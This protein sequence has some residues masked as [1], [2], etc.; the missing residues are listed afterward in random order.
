MPLVNVSGALSEAAQKRLDWIATAYP[1]LPRSATVAHIVN[2]S[3]DGSSLAQDVIVFAMPSGAALAIDSDLLERFPHV[4]RSEVAT[5]LGTPEKTHFFY[6]DA[7]AA[8]PPVNLAYFGAKIAYEWAFGG[9]PT[10]EVGPAT[11]QEGL[12][13]GTERPGP[14]GLTYVLRKF[15]G[16]AFETPMWVGK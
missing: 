5:A 3:P 15:Q 14:A 1:A 6:S 9:K 4:T 11:V 7:I 16:F 12:S 2:L 8:A 13:V 10:Y